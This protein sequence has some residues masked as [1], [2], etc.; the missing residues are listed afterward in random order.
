MIEHKS[1]CIRI[2][3][4]PVFFPTGRHKLV[5]HPFGAGKEH[6]GDA[7]DALTMTAF[8]T[9]KDPRPPLL[10]LPGTACDARVFAPLIE[11][12]G[13]YPVLVGDM[14]GAKTMPDLAE[15]ILAAA[16]PFFLLAGFS[17]G[18]ICALEM[19]A[20]QP[21]RIGG[22][23]LIDA[24]ARPDPP[25]NAAVRRKAVSD[26]RENGMDGFI[27]DAWPRLVAAGNVDNTDL[28]DTIVAMARDCGPDRLAEQAE[29]AI[30]RVDSR[31]R[32]AAIT[33][34]MLVLAGAEEQVCPLEAQHEIAAGIAGAQLHLIAD[35]GHF[36]P[37]EN[38]AAVALHLRR[39]V[40]T[41]S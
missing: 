5:S 20:R 16:P 9:T 6:D 38:P 40:Q 22:L 31:P 15:A 7:S 37:L 41:L 28:R 14:G 25:A 35:A 12:L 2:Q 27:L 24:T 3:N 17:L 29:V 13:D 18:G 32:L 26:A 4:L 8:P 19:V 10:L 23:A 39:W 36:A 30:H 33:Q 21:Q 34:P 11:R 1:Y